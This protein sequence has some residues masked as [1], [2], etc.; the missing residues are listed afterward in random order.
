MK[1]INFTLPQELETE[2]LKIK[3]KRGLTISDLIRRGIELL[4]KE[5]KNERI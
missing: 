3:K 1:R 5:E 2:L 4:I